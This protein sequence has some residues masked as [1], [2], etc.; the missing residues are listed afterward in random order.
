MKRGVEDFLL[1]AVEVF[2]LKNQASILHYIRGPRCT[3]AQWYFLKETLGHITPDSTPSFWPSQPR[4]SSISEVKGTHL[5]QIIIV[6][7]EISDDVASRLQVS[8]LYKSDLQVLSRFANNLMWK[9]LIFL[10]I[11]KVN[12]LDLKILQISQKS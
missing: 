9:K 7:I 11:N 12:S 2:F 10:Q 6:K 8:D 1:K 4:Y 5:W 3:G